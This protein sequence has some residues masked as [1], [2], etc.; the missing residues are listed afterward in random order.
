[1]LT[2][3]A[4]I[5]TR[6]SHNPCLNC[7]RRDFGFQLSSCIYT[8]PYFLY[9]L[10]VALFYTS[11]FTTSLCHSTKTP[12]FLNIRELVFIFIIQSVKRKHVE[13]L[14][15]YCRYVMQDVQLKLR[16]YCTCTVYASL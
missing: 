1:M 5:I 7:N 4:I 8:I 13:P 15:A 14:Y 12:I 16:I 10:T 2:A 11:Y 9:L 6:S 3:L